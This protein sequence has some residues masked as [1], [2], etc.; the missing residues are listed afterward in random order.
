MD[1][2]VIWDVLGNII[3]QKY[4][5]MTTAGDVIISFKWG[6]K[7]AFTNA[8]AELWLILM[9][10][11]LTL[12]PQI[13]LWNWRKHK[14]IGLWYDTRV[15]LVFSFEWKMRNLDNFLA[16]DTLMICWEGQ[17][18]YVVWQLENVWYTKEERNF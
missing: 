18:R 9:F 5:Q 13:L 1:I 11:Q 17:E 16:Q 10:V 12:L 8:V 2:T 15:I 3:F 4:T 14:N 7:E 6:R